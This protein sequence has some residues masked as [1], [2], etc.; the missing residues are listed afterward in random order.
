MNYKK[1][2]AADLAHFKTIVGEEFVFTDEASIDKF[3]RDET[4]GVSFPP[5]V[6]IKPITAQEISAVL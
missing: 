5:E 1:I 2:T 6:V 4:D 3:S